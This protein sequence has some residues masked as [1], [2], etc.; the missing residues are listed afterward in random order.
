MAGIEL[1]E[2]VAEG[3]SSRLRGVAGRIEK[4]ARMLVLRG[5]A[6]PWVRVVLAARWLYER[7]RDN[8]TEA[9]RRELARVVRRSKG[10]PRKV[11]ADERARTRA[12]VAK[13]I[14]GRQS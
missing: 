11:T 10:D 2:R 12:L 5:R 1:G 8:L 9:E 3:C 14:T 4:L 13:G 6:V 7:G